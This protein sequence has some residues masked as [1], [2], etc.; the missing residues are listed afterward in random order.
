VVNI[1]AARALRE[2]RIGIYGGS[3]WRPLIHC[4]DAARAFITAAE[5]PSDDV[6]GE[7]FNIGSNEMNCRI[8]DIG[9]VVADRVPGMV[10]DKREDIED[11]RDYNVCFDKARSVLEFEPQFSLR[12]GV[13]EIV[14]NLESDPSINY[15]ADHY[16][17]VRYLYR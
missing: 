17:N 13:D 2:K 7:V 5:A 1:L 8:Q 4:C 16:Y 14:D 12:E 3:Q 15:L 10:I 11:K 6:A 9:A